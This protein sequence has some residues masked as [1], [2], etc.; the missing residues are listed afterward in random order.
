MAQMKALCNTLRDVGYETVG[1]LTADIA[2]AALREPGAAFDLLL[3]D[4][5]MPNMD[6]IALLQAAQQIDRDLVAIIMTGEGTITTAVD[7]MKAGALDYILK[8]FKLSL[9]VPVL[10]RALRVRRLHIE[11][12]MLEQRLA[13]HAIELERLVTERTADLNDANDRLRKAALFQQAFLRDV[14]ASVTDGGLVLCY[15]A[16]ELP[17]PLI[18]FGDPID[19]SIRTALRQLRTTAFDAAS[20][21]GFSMERINDLV[22]AAHEAAMNSVVHVGSGTASVS[23]DDSLVRV[24]IEDTGPGITLEALPKATLQKGYTTAGTFGHGMK[25]MLY[26]VDRVFLRTGPDG[27]TVVLEQH[28]EPLVNPYVI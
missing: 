24:H 8:P 21:E 27:T 12:E 28:R 3:A 2:L 23:L 11:K 1:C 19:L 18:A 10:H 7:A 17:P 14:L 6:G 4:L 15:N 16:D 13:E 22:A 5:M 26:M 9:I 25:L 20:K